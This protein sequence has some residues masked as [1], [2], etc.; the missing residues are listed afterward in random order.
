MNTQSVLKTG[1]K[2][3]SL[4]KA[5]YYKKFGKIH[6]PVIFKE[7]IV[8]L[9]Y[10]SKSV[11]AELTNILKSLYPYIKSSG[12][13]SSH[14]EFDKYVLWWIPED[15]IIPI[16]LKSSKNNIYCIHFFE[17]QKYEIDY[18]GYLVYDIKKTQAE[19]RVL[20]NFLA[21]YQ[22]LKLIFIKIKLGEVVSSKFIPKVELKNSLQD[23]TSI[24][25]SRALGKLLNLIVDD[26]LKLSNVKA[27]FWITDNI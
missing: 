9:N 4:L 14:T 21:P 19:D 1:I 13:F 25:Y 8:E 27:S 2:I 24:Y 20:Y 10:C 17:L 15:N 18:I 7:H 16:V 3:L 12:H 5:A 26:N 6:K 11:Q 23:C 22:K